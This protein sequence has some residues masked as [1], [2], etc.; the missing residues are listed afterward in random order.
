MLLQ[1]KWRLESVAINLWSLCRKADLGC[2][3][4]ATRCLSQSVSPK[5]TSWS[6]HR[7]CPRLLQTCSIC[8]DYDVDTVG[9]LKI[10]QQ[11]FWL[12]INSFIRQKCRT[13]AGFSFLCYVWGFV[14]QHLSL[15]NCGEHFRS[16]LTQQSLN[17]WNIQFHLLPPWVVLTLEKVV[18]FHTVWLAASYMFLICL[19]SMFIY[20]CLLP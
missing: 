1:F 18:L 5:L 7:K 11:W 15:W 9:P 2:G 12:L 13:L 10:N 14:C 17:K 20:V 3:Q 6:V 19:C 16:F 8:G 4:W